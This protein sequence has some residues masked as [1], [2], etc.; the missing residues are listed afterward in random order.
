[1]TVLRAP[2]VDELPEV[3]ALCLSS[4]AYWGYDAAFMAACVDELTLH[5]EELTTSHLVVLEDGD[6]LCGMC[7]VGIDGTDADLLKLF[8]A[9]DQIGRGHGRRL[10]EWAIS[11][12]RDQGA[13]RLTIEADPG[14][15]PFYLR[16][17]AHRIGSV[18]S[19]S[20]PGRRLPLLELRL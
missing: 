8:V 15:E 9:T 6:A 13:H 7:Q 1:M 5:P 2:T 14:A 10:I 20:I 4:K 17:G 16:A 11:V 19:G 12:A 18:A 3:S